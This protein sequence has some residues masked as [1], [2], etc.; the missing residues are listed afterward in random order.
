MRLKRAA[1]LLI[2]LSLF[3]FIPGNSDKLCSEPEKIV[4]EDF[5]KSGDVFFREWKNMESSAS[6]WEE[7]YLASENGKN[8]LRAST[9]RN[10]ALSIQIGKVVNNKWNIFNYPVI[11]WEWRVHKV[12]ANGNETR[13]SRRDSAAGIYVLFQRKKIPL[14]GWQHQPMNWIK[15]VWSSTLPVGTVVPRK[16]V[17]SGVTLY[18]G[19]YVVVA[20]GEKDL[21]KWISFKMDGVSYY[22]TYFGKAPSANPVMVALLTVSNK[23]KSRAV[24]D[25][26]NIIVQRY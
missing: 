1:A 6:P 10:P 25:Y 8:F 18:D 7:Y 14:V 11:S 3:P 22:K 15:Y 19:R 21:G 12:P 26:A 24:A 20:S 9:E 5:N 17:Q 23:T 2:L 4:I 13:S 16:K